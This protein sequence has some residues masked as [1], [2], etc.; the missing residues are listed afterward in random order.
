[1]AEPSGPVF[2][3]G[4]ALGHNGRPKPGSQVFGEFV[5]LGIT[6]DFDG[7]LGGIGDNVAIVAPGQ[8]LFKLGLCAGVNYSVQI[9]GEFVEEISALHWLPSPLLGFGDPFALS[10]L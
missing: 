3:S 9:I 6:I 8:V 5:K 1:V 10:R 7:L 2:F 4:L